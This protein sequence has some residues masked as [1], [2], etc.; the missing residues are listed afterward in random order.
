MSHHRALKASGLLAVAAILCLACGGS[1]G[2]GGGGSAKGEIDIGVDLPMSGAE[3]SN[4][5][6]TLNGVNFAV[7]Q[8]NDKGGV[9]G[10]TIKVVSL[11]DAVSGKHDPQKGAQNIQQLLSDSKV[12]AMVGPFNSNVAA[13]EIPVANRGNL[14]MVSP[15][16]TNPCLTKQV[17]ADF[18]G[19]QN[20]AG[21]DPQSLR[22]T[23]T[24]NY[25]RVAGTDDHQGPANADYAYNTLHISKIAVGDDAEAYGKGIAQTFIAQF[26]KL[27]GTVVGSLQDFDPTTTNDFRTFLR[28]AVNGGAQGIYF[29]GVDAN[30]ACIV[31]NQMKGIFPDTAPFFGGDG[32][33]TVQCLSD[34]AANAPGMYGTTATK[35]AD[36]VPNA[37][38]TIDA[39]HKQYTGDIDYGSYTIPAY[40]CAQLIMNAI[41]KAVDANGGNMP[42]RKQVLD[43][44]S[45]TSNFGSVL[46]PVTFDKNGDNS[47][48]IMSLYKSEAVDPSKKYLEETDNKQAGWIFVQAKDYSTT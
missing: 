36:Q 3:A 7:K 25:F 32:I 4:G 37:R 2:N 15:A 6:P 18:G 48:Q 42:S 23:G 10:Y 33:V 20:Y 21:F 14:S 13:A 9:S 16:N 44:L 12:L 24:N 34:A 27:G 22:P 11:D 29:G 39:F 30:K 1:G 8:Q 43:Q 28:S 47:Q 41:G 31:R 45:K 46:G 17:S 26:K 19:C 38:A 40:A 5:V 35:D